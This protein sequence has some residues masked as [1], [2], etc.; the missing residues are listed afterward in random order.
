MNFQEA[1]KFYYDL[2]KNTPYKPVPLRL[3]K[4]L[5]KRL[6]STHYYHG[7]LPYAVDISG[8]YLS[9]GND[10]DIKDTLKHEFAHVC[11]VYN[12]GYT[13]HDDCWKSIIISLGG[14]PEKAKKLDN[15]TRLFKYNIYCL[16][17]KKLVAQYHRLTVRTVH[18]YDSEYECRTCGCREF[19]II[20]NFKEDNL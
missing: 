7:R 4:R 19:E 18:N 16:S 15:N 3:N 10:E 6:G 12:R 20:D 11:D 17:C 8:N 9:C 13:N 5:F 14:S 1:E 2:Y